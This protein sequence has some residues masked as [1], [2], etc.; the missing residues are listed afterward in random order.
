MIKR[1]NYM[2][3]IRPF[4]GQEL[5][6]VLTGI[7]RCGKSVMLSLIQ[8]ELLTQG[9]PKTQFISYNFE[10]L[11]NSHLTKAQALH[12]EISRRI[13]ALP[14]KVYLFL[15]EIQEV[16][17]WEKCVNSLRVEYDCDIYITGSNARLLS[18]E[19]ATYLAGRYV[20]FVIHPFSFTEFIQAAN[21]AFPE[22]GKQAL[23]EQYLLLGGMP[24]LKNL[25]FEE[26]PSRQ[27]LQDVY[28]SV[29]LKDVVKRNAIRDVDLLECIIGYV[30]SNIGTT[31]SATSIMRYFKSE[32]RTVATETILNYLKYCEDA[33]LIC[34]V[35]RQD[36]QGKKLLTVNEKYYVADHGLREA[37]YGA[38]TRDIS[39]VLENIVFM[40]LTRRGYQVR[41]GKVGD[42][43]IDFVCLRRQKKLYIQVSYLL[44]SPETID[45]EFR[46]YQSIS[47]NFPKYVISMDAFDMSRAGIKHRNMMDFL[48]MDAWD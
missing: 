34:R 40:E 13:A 18:G 15:D 28:N 5:I 35:P 11:H 3:M 42:R 38:N 47:D 23:F 19:L 12:Q 24:Y 14:G 31:F 20:E 21:D 9:V 30:F 25:R 37:V 10:D 27:Y 17:A 36:L 29:V 46:V 41:V 44:A 1:E 45:R 16:S 8:D 43:E 22:A 4:I 33:Y 32:N 48:L 2:R 26:A 39:L 7:R 6:K